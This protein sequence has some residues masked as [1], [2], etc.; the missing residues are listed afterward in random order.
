MQPHHPHHRHRPIAPFNAGYPHV[1]PAHHS[2]AP[3]HKQMYAIDPF[4][5]IENNAYH[6]MADP[7][8]YWHQWHNV[9]HPHEFYHGPHYPAMKPVPAIELGNKSSSASDTSKKPAAPLPSKTEV[10]EE[11]SVSTDG[12]PYVFST[13]TTV[14]I[15]PDLD[16]EDEFGLFHPDLDSHFAIEGSHKAAAAAAPVVDSHKIL[17][18]KPQTRDVAVNTDLSQGATSFYAMYHLY[19]QMQY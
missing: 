6:P 15:D 12:K 7:L 2:A 17:G 9:P 18:N 14:T 13:R 11:K 8:D 3:A 1:H 16:L 5:Y 19:P 4:S 10:S